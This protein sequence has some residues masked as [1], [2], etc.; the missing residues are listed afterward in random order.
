MMLLPKINNI[1]S[2]AIF[3]TAVSLELNIFVGEILLRLIKIED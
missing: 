2:E 3:H 1:V